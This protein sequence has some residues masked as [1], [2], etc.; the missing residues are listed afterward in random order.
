MR[1]FSPPANWTRL[2]RATES[3]VEEALLKLLATPPD[4]WLS[5]TLVVFRD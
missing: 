1:G 4:E 3:G 5:P 2:H